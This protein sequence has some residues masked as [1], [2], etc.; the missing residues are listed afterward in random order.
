MENKD[1]PTLFVDIIQNWRKIEKEA[2]SI[3][4]KELIDVTMEAN[5][6]IQSLSLF[7]CNEEIEEVST[8][9]LKYM[10]VKFFE[11]EFRLKPHE[12]NPQLVT[13]KSIMGCLLSY[14]KILNDYGL[15]CP[16]KSYPDMRTQKIEMFKRKKEIT[17]SMKANEYC[18]E[19]ESDDDEVERK[20]WMNF[21]T[22]A[23]LISNEHMSMLKRELEMLKMRDAGV[24]PEQ[25]KPR[26]PTQPFMIAKNE[27]MKRVFGL[28]YPSRPVYTVE[29]FGEKQVEL[30]RQQERE[31]TRQMAANPPRDESLELTWAEEDAQR[32]KDQMWDDHKDT[33]RRGDGNRKNMG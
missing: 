25:P 22:F 33:T 11:A 8:K 12:A 15:A 28:G 1:L 16:K 14:L 4:Y 23:E 27:E 31:K 3:D 30:M 6:R 24:R 21:I 9:S 10:L 20:Y 7:S 19:D 26:P 32:K 5:D 29:E 17:E 18:L 2:A 13:L